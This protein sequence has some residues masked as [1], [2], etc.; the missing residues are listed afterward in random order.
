MVTLRQYPF[1]IDFLDAPDKY[2]EL[3]EIQERL[4]SSGLTDDQIVTLK[5]LGILIDIDDGGCLLQ[6]FTKPL[7][8]RPT[9]FV[10]IIQ[11]ICYGDEIPG[12][13]RFGSGNFKALFISLEPL[14]NP[15]IPK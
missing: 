14:L 7:F 6:I 9:V 13:G 12:C 3:P 15:N 1:S 11:R 2:Y 5:K 4:K 8:D 10:E